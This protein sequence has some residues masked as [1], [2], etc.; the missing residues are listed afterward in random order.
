MIPSQATGRTLHFQAAQKYTCPEECVSDVVTR[1]VPWSTPGKKIPEP[2]FRE[3]FII[4]P[5]LAS[6]SPIIR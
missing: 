1:Y 6:S 4:S 3:I 5:S 2:S